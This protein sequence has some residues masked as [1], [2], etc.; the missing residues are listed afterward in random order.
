MRFFIVGVL[1]L[2]LLPLVSSELGAQDLYFRWEKRTGS[3]RYGVTVPL[4]SPFGGARYGAPAADYGGAPLWFDYQ[5]RTRSSTYGV[6]VPLPS[7][8]GASRYDSYAPAY[9]SPYDRRY[10]AYSGFPRRYGSG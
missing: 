3:S 10:P 8:F 1:A 5:K 2:A 7:P 6:S 9:G 4:A